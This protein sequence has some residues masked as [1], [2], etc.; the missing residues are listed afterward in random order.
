M[1][2]IFITIKNENI[3]NNNYC[4]I[5]FPFDNINILNGL[6]EIGL[7]KSTNNRYLVINDIEPNVLKQKILDKFDNNLITVIIKQNVNTFNPN[8]IVINNEISSDV[9]SLYIQQLTLRR[10]S[11]KTIKSYKN[12]FANF[13]FYY[14][15]EHPSKLDTINVIN[16]IL[17]KIN[18]DNISESYQN[19]IINAIKFWYEKIEK[20]KKVF[21][22]IQRPKLPN[23][24]PKVLSK[25][26]IKSMIDLTQNIKHKCM[27]MLLYGAGLRLSEVLSLIPTD[28]DSKRMLITIR[29]AKG[30]KDRTVS[31]PTKLLDLLREYWKMYKPQ[32]FLF[33]GEHIGEQ[34]SE[35]SLQ[36]VVKQAAERAN[37]P[38]TVTAHMLRH[39]FATHLLERGTDIRYIQDVLGHSNIKTTERYTHI[40]A[41][42]KPK[43]PLDDL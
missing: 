38:R 26:E 6:I 21:Y 36:Y 34:Y 14:K 17:H 18:I 23:T 20:R 28:I 40:N 13:L 30:K 33:E 12:A 2:E 32:T 37:I 15:N 5:Y 41:N 19:T 39:S 3:S 1:K 42:T 10:Y 29:Q 4:K 25:L 35:R 22:D 7:L 11:Y 27:L 43:S 8:E 31:L 24:Q 9:M 16:Y